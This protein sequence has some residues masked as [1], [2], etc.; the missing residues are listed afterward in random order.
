MN[1]ALGM[2]VIQP[3]QQLSA[4]DS[5]L[6]FVEDAWL[7]LWFGVSHSFRSDSVDWRIKPDVVS[8][9]HQVKTTSPS[10]IFHHDPESP[11]S[12]ETAVVPRDVVRVTCR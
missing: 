11:T 3:D 8:A 12:D 7:E 4:N 9:T 1:L 10:E 6:L 5:D 2:K